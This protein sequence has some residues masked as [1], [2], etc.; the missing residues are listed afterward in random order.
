MGIVF[1]HVCLSE[2]APRAL[3]NALFSQHVLALGL[4]VDATHCNVTKHREAQIA[5]EEAVPELRSLPL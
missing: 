3:F 2:F 4:Y 5:A 1:N